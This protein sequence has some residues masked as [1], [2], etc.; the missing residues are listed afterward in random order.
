MRAAIRAC[1]RPCND[2]VRSV[3]KN[4]LAAILDLLRDNNPVVVAAARAK[5][6]SLGQAAEEALALAA[7]QDDARLRVRARAALLE[8][9]QAGATAELL[10]MAERPSAG[11]DIEQGSFAIARID[12]PDLDRTACN[13]ILDALGTELASRVSVKTPPHGAA[14]E[15]SRLLATEWRLRLNEENFDDPDNS[16]I[17]RVLERRRGIPISLAAVYLSVAR[18]AQLPLHG[19]GSPGHYLLRF[20]GPELN[21]YI[22]PTSGRRLK[23]D[24]CARMLAVRGFPVTKEH[25][26][27]AGARETLIRM[28]SNLAGVHER[29]GARARAALW[30]RFREAFRDGGHPKPAEPGAPPK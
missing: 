27:P 7:S 11:L 6:I 4:T 24:E 12:Y 16:F 9:R 10:K 19:I 25:F 5:L 13:A 8:I 15:L 29:R 1:P 30:A 2:S 17:H 14:A 3:D 22:D 20:G 26:E 28:C 23:M 21:L 18:R